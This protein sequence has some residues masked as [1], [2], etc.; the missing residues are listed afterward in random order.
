MRTAV[1]SCA[2]I[3][4]AVGVGACGGSGVPSN[5]IAVVGSAPVTSAQF[6]H[7]MT[8][9]NN[10]PYVNSATTP[11][12]L[13]VPPK[14]TA[15]IASE[16][17]RDPSGAAT[18]FEAQC[19]ATYTQLNQEVTALLIEGIWFQGEAF[20][21]HVKVT[22]AAINASWNQERKTNFATPAKL[23][24]FLGE[25]GY[26][27]DDLKWVAMLNLLQQ[28]I[29]KKVEKS[30]GR[31]APAQIAAYYKSHLSQ[32]TQPERRNLELVLVSS[33]ATET[34]VKSLLSGGASFA[35]VAKQYSID[36]TTKST[37][38][39]Q[40]G[41]Q[42]GEETPIFN[43]AIFNSPVGVLAST[44]KTPFGYYVFKVTAAMR[45]SVESLAAARAAI[46]LQLV[47][48]AQTAAVDALRTSFV[49]KWKARTTC[50]SGHLVAQV[51]A[52]APA[53]ASTG[54]SGTTGAT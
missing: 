12:A 24:T 16:R 1:A 42:Q 36:P 6:D 7:W 32:Y 13:P 44:A 23:A 37:G 49:S 27:I 33:V 3:A 52:N 46:K 30:A 18:T 47:N 54:S 50:A 40:S 34:K 41:V 4:T 38:G 5:A 51:C 8:V 10:Q 45:A 43:T 48:Q 39:V 20:D 19:A 9:A 17:L 2:A 22:K 11:P 53:S 15:C 14:Y 28:G 29:V 21:R 25:S 35:S 31:V 26:T